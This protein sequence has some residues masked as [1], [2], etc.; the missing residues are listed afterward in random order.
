MKKTSRRPAIAG[1]WFILGAALLWGT[2]GTA[3]AFSPAGFDP[4]VV[5]ELRLIIGG[6]ALMLMALK[7]R[8]LGQ[9]SDWK[10]I[11][12]L[13]A[14]C[15][16]ASFQICFFSAVAKTGVAVGTVVAVGSAPIVGGLLGRIFRAEELNGRWYVATVLAIG[17]CTLLSLSSGDITVDLIG[18][19]LALGAGMSYSGYSLMIK[20]MLGRVSSNAVMAV[21]VCL[22]ALL[23]SPL[24]VNVDPKWLWQPSSVLVLLHL[25][26]ITMAVGY[27]LFA[28]GLQTVN[29]ATATTLALA[30]PLTAALLGVVV[31][32]EQLTTQALLG[33][34]LIFSGLVV[35]VAKRRQNV[36]HAITT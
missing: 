4:K 2:C 32:G 18:I 25:G 30:E 11:P 6:T 16:I 19:L 9:W 10:I 23:L 34:V 14:A 15:F 3:Q 35:L 1:H 24:L 27:G 31:L 17:G 20:G 21:I 13:I 7:Q 36:Q 5:G 12:T 33:I 26:L 22:A 29:I 8:G 28:V